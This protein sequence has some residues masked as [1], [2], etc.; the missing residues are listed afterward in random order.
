[1]NYLLQSEHAAWEV[2]LKCSYSS[3]VRQ[4][5]TCIRNSPDP[6]ILY[7]EVGLA[8]ETSLVRR[9]PILT[10][11]IL[12]VGIHRSGRA[13]KFGKGWERLSRVNDVKGGC[14]GGQCQTISTCTINLRASFL[15]VKRQSCERLGSCLAIEHLKIKSSMLFHVFEYGPLPPRPPD[16]I[17]MINVP[18][19]SL[20]LLLFCSRVLY[21]TQ[22]EGGGSS[23]GSPREGGRRV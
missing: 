14:R 18:R 10:L 2:Q 19:P 9:L 4:D 11:H 8:C 7:A 21:W 17:H 3:T 16:I 5:T 23:L 22:T 13:V 6:S 12:C 20:F 15:S 1:M